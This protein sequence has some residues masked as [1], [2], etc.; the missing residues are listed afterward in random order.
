MRWASW[1]LIVTAASS[2]DAAKVL[3]ASGQLPWA[4]GPYQQQLGILATALQDTGHTVFWFLAASVPGSSTY[5]VDDVATLPNTVKPNDKD[6]KKFSKVHFVFSESEVPFSTSSF[7]QITARHSLEVV[8]L[9][10][11]VD[12]L[13]VD[14][15]FVARVSVYWFPNHFQKLD[16]LTR[17]RLSAFTHVAAL[18]P[19]DVTMITSDALMSSAS[20]RPNVS[21]VPHVV[22]VPV[23]VASAGHASKVALRKHFGVPAD[24]FIV[25]VNSANYDRENRKSY[26]VCLLAFKQL[27]EVVPNAFLYFHVVSSE[28]VSES[29][30]GADHPPSMTGVALD[31]M[32]YHVQLPQAAYIWDD[33]VLPYAEV[34]QLLQMAD[35]LLQPS[36]TEGF[37]MPILEAQLLGT[38][39]VTTKFGVSE[40]RKAERTP[41]AARSSAR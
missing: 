17:I 32:G 27:L 38:P 10:R 15:P 41:P 7:N 39:V 9:L 23:E 36:K 12:A 28:G 26:D 31:A 3:L 29:T 16:P 35:V 33:R 1:W 30:H 22:T 20:R 37:G 11:D 34:L 14:E 6:R 5:G 18:S 25:V 40:G 2:A 4:W 19:G 24:A 13:Q 21:F 8:I